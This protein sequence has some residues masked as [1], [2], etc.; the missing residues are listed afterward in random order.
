MNS[1]PQ[2]DHNDWFVT[3]PH[4]VAAWISAVEFYEITPAELFGVH[5]TLNNISTA[6][7][8][9]LGVHADVPAAQQAAKRHL[10]DV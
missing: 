5:L 7:A 8:E 9:P 3:S 2:L 10:G 4:T 6:T 1:I